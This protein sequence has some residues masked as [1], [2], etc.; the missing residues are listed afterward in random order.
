MSLRKAKRQQIISD[1][2]GRF[3]NRAIQG[4]QPPREFDNSPIAVA[5]REFVGA[6]TG[7]APQE[8]VAGCLSIL[9]SFFADS[10]IA[11]ARLIYRVMIEEGLIMG[12]TVILSRLTNPSCLDLINPLIRDCLGMLEDISSFEEEEEQALASHGV[13]PR[14]VSL[15]QPAVSTLEHQGLDQNHGRFIFGVFR[16]SITILSNLCQSAKYDAR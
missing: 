10:S 4:Q 8:V 16:T 2:R 9:S 7:K 3:M 5:T 13:V 11:Q 1:K 12:I 15:L 14:L 6:V